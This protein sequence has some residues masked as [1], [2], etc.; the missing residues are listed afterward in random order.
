MNEKKPL[1]LDAG[2]FNAIRVCRHGPMVY[3]KNDVYIGRAL[4]KY[5]ESSEIEQE[6]FRQLVRTGDLV[7]EVGANIGTHTVGL[8]RLVGPS[9]VVFAF[10]PQRLVF[11]SLCANLALNQCANVYAFNEALGAQSGE[12]AV[13]ATNPFAQGNFG[14]LSLIGATSGDRVRMR[15]LDSLQLAACHLLKVDV[16]GMEID[17]LRGALETIAKFRPALYV[18]NDREEKSKE[19]IGL[20]FDSGYHAYWHLPPLFNP[21]NF[22]KDPENAFPGVVSINMLCLPA[23]AG[24]K[25]GGM[26]RIVSP[27][28]SWRG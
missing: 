2:G 26:R 9:G 10:E 12:I 7:V 14:G 20:V 21:D 28:D 17:V 15:T 16:E 22:A 23:E 27:A 11:Q 13:P 4:E 19:L 25:V 6:F 8:S 24:V 3:N 18:E 1:E 5:G